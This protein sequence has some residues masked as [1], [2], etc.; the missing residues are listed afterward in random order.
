MSTISPRI[1]L[2]GCGKMGGAMLSGW[3]HQ[4][5]DKEAIAVIEPGT[6]LAASVSE[7]FDVSVFASPQVAFQHHT[8]PFDAVI[9]AV[10]P[11]MMAEVLKDYGHLNPQSL[12][13]SIAAG[14]GLSFFET[15]LHDGMAII[16]VMPNTPAAIGAGMSVCCPNAQVTNEQRDLADQLL[17]ATGK[18]AWLD[19]EALMDAVTAVSGSGPAYLFWMTD[20]LAKAGVKAGLSPDLAMTLARQTVAGS[21]QL[22]AASDDDVQTLRENVTSPGGTT[23]AAL[24]VLMADGGL[25]DLMTRAVAAAT[26]RSIELGQ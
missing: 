2:V 17:S 24:A 7:R 3:L 26:E 21:A 4:G 23:A 5:I 14:L 8:D 12:V 1:L 20:C 6:D 13:L 10:K 11:Q 19:D 25:E 9:F 18:V 16:R 22:M 15:R